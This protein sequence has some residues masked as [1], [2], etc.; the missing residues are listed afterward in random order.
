MTKKD[1]ELLAHLLAAKNPVQI[2]EHRNLMSDEYCAGYIDAIHQVVAALV[3]DSGT[4]GSFDG[5]RFLTACYNYVP[6]KGE[7]T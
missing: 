2:D 3:E 6:P 4:S 5:P 1:Y 7:G